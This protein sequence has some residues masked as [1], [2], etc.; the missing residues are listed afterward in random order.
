MRGGRSWQR[1][2]QVD[3]GRRV[4]V[5]IAVLLVCDALLLMVAADVQPAAGGVDIHPLAL[6]AL[7]AFVEWRVIHVQFRSETN[8]FS[9]FE[10]PLV[11]G[12]LYSSPVHV[13]VATA[14]GVAAGLIIGR[15]QAPIK[16]AFNVANLVLYAAVAIVAMSL[17]P[18]VSADRWLWLSTL[19]AMVL[20]S[21]ASFGVIVVAVSLTEGFPRWR[22]IAELLWFAVLVSVANTTV[23]LTSAVLL[24]ADVLGVMFLAVPAY[25]LFRSFRMV[26]EEREQRE[27]VEFLYRSTQ[28]LDVGRSDAGLTALLRE[29]RDMFRAEIAAMVLVDDETE[30][31]IVVSAPDRDYSTSW[32]DNQDL[33]LTHAGLELVD[34]LQMVAPD[35]P[36]PLGSMVRKLGGRDAMVAKLRTDLRELGLL[37]IANRLGD[38]TSFTANDL[39]VVGAL[40]RQSAMLMHSDHLESAL[41]ELRRLERQLAYQATHDSLTGLPNR[42]IFVGALQAASSGDQPHAVLFVDL[43]G[44]KAVNDSYGHAAGDAVLVEVASRLRSAVRPIDTVARFGGDEFAVLLLDHQRPRAVAERIVTQM[45]KPIPVDDVA[46]T[47]GCSVGIAMSDSDTESDEVINQADAA[48]YSAKRAGKGVVVTYDRHYP[49]ATVQVHNR[50]REALDLDQLELHYQPIVDVT[51]RRITGIEGL[52]RWRSPEHGLLLPADFMAQAERTSLVTAIDRWVMTQAA[53]DLTDT[54]DLDPGFFVALN[55]SAQHLNDG[56]F[57]DFLVREDLEPLRHR[58]VV[59]WPEAVLM[60]TV[61]RSESTLDQLRPLGIRIA[62]D[63]FG[64]GYSSLSYLTRLQI[65][66]LKVAGPAIDKPGRADTNQV[67]IDNMIRIGHALG[68]EVIAEDVETRQ[69][70]DALIRSGCTMAQGFLFARPLTIEELR[71]LLRRASTPTSS[72]ISPHRLV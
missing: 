3:A 15:R 44:F 71:P 36:G 72:S 53:Q 43:D 18:Q 1:L 23:G 56:S 26:T 69:Q 14:V 10:V 39:Q 31:R 21:I 33:E 54:D 63:R 12:L 40:A 11:L 46:L 30:H 32:T 16:V 29:A 55:L 61:D 13:L 67:L 57:M 24:R 8:N 2:K 42:S 45:T 52:V 68:L 62:L 4:V 38:V 19:V 35:E 50:L 6:A 41:A 70:L 17:L 20:G 9:L 60:A 65:D 22:K 51:E 5:L 28:R 64:T 25:V 37:V 27:R 34:H 58:L 49:I 48:M 66:I 7:F 59:E 47:I